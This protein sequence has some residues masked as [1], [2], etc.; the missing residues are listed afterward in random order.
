MRVCVCA[1]AF[2]CAC[3]YAYAFSVRV[4]GIVCMCV[5]VCLPVSFSVRGCVV[6]IYA[7]N[8]PQ[9]RRMRMSASACDSMRS[10]FDS[11][12]VSTNAKDSKATTD[13]RAGRPR[14]YRL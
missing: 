7:L 1:C 8:R 2:G 9:E 13:S 11:A 3:A 10:A 14:R 5:G 12:A 6:C 4:L